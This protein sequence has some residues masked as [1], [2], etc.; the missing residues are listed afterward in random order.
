MQESWYCINGHLATGTKFYEQTG[1]YYWANF[2]SSYPIAGYTR[3]ETHGPW[4]RTCNDKR[5]NKGEN[6]NE[7]TRSN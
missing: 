3:L 6:Q 7:E 4:C 5:L 1:G 2:M